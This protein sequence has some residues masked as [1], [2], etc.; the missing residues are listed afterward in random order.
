DAGYRRR[1]AN[2][3]PADCQAGARPALPSPRRRPARSP[4]VRRR[5]RT[6]AIRAPTERLHSPT[7]PPRPMTVQPAAGSRDLHRLRARLR[8]HLAR[9]VV[10]AEAEPVAPAAALLLLVDRLRRLAR[11]ERRRETRHEGEPARTGAACVSGVRPDHPLPVEAVVADL[12]R[13]AWQTLE[14]AGPHPHA[15]GRAVQTGRLVLVVADPDHGQ[16]VAGIAGEPAV[17]AVVAGTGLAG[18]AEPA[19]PVGH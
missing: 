1:R 3:A 18:R 5:H 4:R 15:T 13:C 16:V 10:A 12:Q 2:P 17:A 11:L 7:P 14:D 8:F 6:R 9:V 19:E